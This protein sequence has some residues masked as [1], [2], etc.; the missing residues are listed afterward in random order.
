VETPAEGWAEA[1]TALAGALRGQGSS[2][3]ALVLA[4]LAL[5]LR[6]GSGPALVLTADAMADEKHDEQALAALDA[7]AADDA[8][9]PV[10]ALRR[11]S[12]LDS[13]GRT[14][15]AIEVLRRLAADY[16]AM[17]QPLAR[18]GDL[19]RR[20]D[21][22][23][24]AAR[25][26]DEA[27]SR[28]PSPDGGDWPLFYARGI[29][30]ERS[31]DWPRAEADFKRALQLA[32]EQPYV[33]NYLGYS[34]ADQGRNLD[35]AKA[36][37]LRATELRPQDGNIAD[38]LGWVLFRLG[39]HKGAVRWLEKAVELEPRSAVIN[40]HLGDAYWAAARQREA[41]F[42]WRRALLLDPEPGEA[43]K[44]EAKLRDGLPGFPA[45]HAQR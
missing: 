35:E 27:I 18:L 28:I 5:R 32:P 34:W 38:S 37:L 1:Y 42:Q 26:Y 22:F 17:P 7:V 16:P 33:L 40:D 21:R 12:L 20:H 19:L 43:P 4:Q 45:S 44:I 39:D 10:A 9:A 3:F 41:Q 31:D 15:E 23:A 8:L 13:M 25:A 14:Q 36:M 2:D 29:A 11:A 30:R 6:P 24:E